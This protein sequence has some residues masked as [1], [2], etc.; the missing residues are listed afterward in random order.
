VTLIGEA[1][2]DVMRNPDQPFVIHTPQVDIRVLGTS[3][4]VRSYP[5]EGLTETSLIRGSLQ[6]KVKNTDKSYILKP[7]E[8]FIVKSA[9]PVETLKEHNQSK[10]EPTTS[11]V[12]VNHFEELDNIVIETAWVDD[13]L[14]FDNEPLK[15]IAYSMARWYNVEISILDTTIQQLKFHGAFENQSIQEAMEIISISMDG[16]IKYTIQGNKIVITK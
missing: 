8:K 10:I 15:D 13:R 3:F 7:E 5:L 6:V 12:K 2:F 16:K 1:F 4:N 9:Q 14:I 11:L